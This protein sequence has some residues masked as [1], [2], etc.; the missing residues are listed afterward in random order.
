MFIFMLKMMSYP[1]VR[2]YLYAGK[3]SHFISEIFPGKKKRK[4]IAKVMKSKI[5]IFWQIPLVMPPTCHAF[6][7]PCSYPV[8]PPPRV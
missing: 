6:S 4:K 2:I 7:R 5:K 8:F 1:V 3:C